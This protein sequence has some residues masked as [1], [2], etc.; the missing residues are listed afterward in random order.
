MT[1]WTRF[2][3]GA[4]ARVTTWNYNPCRGWLDSKQYADG[5]GPSYLYT[6]AGRLQTRTWARGL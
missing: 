5:H 6:A 1:N 3:A 2:A 4:G